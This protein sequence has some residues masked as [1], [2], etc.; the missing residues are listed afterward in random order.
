MKIYVS[1]KAHRVGLVICNNEDSIYYYGSFKTQSMDKTCQLTSAS[2]R[3]ISYIKANKLIGVDNTINVYSDTLVEFPNIP[4]YLRKHNFTLTSNV[5]TTD[6]E[7]QRLLL[8]K[9]ETEM[10]ERRKAIGIKER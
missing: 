9:V 4:E 5:A 3:A 8:A 1:T 2:Q 6:K 10:A 7:K